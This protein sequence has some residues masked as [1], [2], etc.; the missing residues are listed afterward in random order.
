MSLL[1]ETRRIL[2]VSG[3]VPRKRLGQNFLVDAESLRKMVSYASLGSEETVLEVGAGLGFLTERLAKAAGR[4]IAVEIDPRLVRILK[5]RFRGVGNVI[6]LQGDVMKVDVQCFD[7]VVS[8]P[9][10]SISSPLLFWLL[11]RKFKQA[12]L[13]FQEEFARRLAAAVGSDDY[14]RLTVTV[15]YRA[16]VEL[17]DLVPRGLF[18]PSPEVD[19]MIVRLTPR[20]PPFSVEDEGVFFDVVRAIFTQKN[21]KLRNAVMPF[22]GGFRMPKREAVKLADSLPFHGRRP[23]ELSPEEIGLVANEVIEILQGLGLR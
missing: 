15:Y 14:G 3:I 9:P 1:R 17:L 13:A 2:R 21:K 20:V 11:E 16:G 4:V 6:V 7:K 19:S 5:D 8:T 22:F 10:Y 12:V 18:W 23:R